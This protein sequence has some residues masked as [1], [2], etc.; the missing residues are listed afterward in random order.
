MLLFLINVY[1]EIAQCAS[2]VRGLKTQSISSSNSSS[3]SKAVAGIPSSSI[4]PSIK[5]NTASLS[6]L[7]NNSNNN[8]NGSSSNSAKKHNHYNNSGSGEGRKGGGGDFSFNFQEK[9]DNEDEE[10]NRDDGNDRGNR[11]LPQPA[12]KK[13]RAR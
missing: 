6:S 5:F 9:S 11:S 4:K 12:V 10:D 7:N 13:L 1:L 3:V 2:L 8:G